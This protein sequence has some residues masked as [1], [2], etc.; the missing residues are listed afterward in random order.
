[1][2]TLAEIRNAVDAQL[3]VIWTK[4]QTWEANYLAVHGGY[5]QGIINPSVIP[6]DNNEVALNLARRPTDQIEDWAAA[7]LTLPATLPMAFQI[8]VH[9]GPSG[10]GYTGTVYVKVLGNTYMRKQ[11]VGA[12]STTAAWL[13]VRP[14]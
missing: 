5:W 9:N 13:L 4:V 8:D 3:A 10:R 6:A 11:G 14:A 7:N 12:H 2:A 1:M